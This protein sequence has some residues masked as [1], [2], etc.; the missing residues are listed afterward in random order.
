MR[1]FALLTITLA[2]MTGL[3]ALG[4][5]GGGGGSE[6]VTYEGSTMPSVIDTT[7]AVD[8][9]KSA[10]L[11]G[12]DAQGVLPMSV[13]TTRVPSDP[14]KMV[15]YA[16]GV[17]A[18]AGVSGGVE[19]LSAVEP[20]AYACSVDE[21][22]D[23]SGGTITEEFCIDPVREKIRMTLSADGYDDGVEAI[24]GVIIIEGGDSDVTVIFRDYFY[25]DLFAGDEDFYADGIVT[26]RES[27]STITIT[28]NLSMYD[29]LT[30]EGFWLNNYRL[31]VVED[32][33][34]EEDTVTI[35]GRFYDYHGGYV[36]IST[37]TPLVVPWNEDYPVIGELQMTG[38]NGYWIKI[39]FDQDISD[40][41]WFQ[42]D[43]NVDE[44]PEYDWQSAWEYWEPLV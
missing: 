13:G 27:G 42:V 22:D 14:A 2:L 26:M 44:D 15:A 4:C 35:T 1:K 30:D 6:E 24:D 18:G 40:I 11:A 3:M 34:N 20:L 28:Y 23:G 8:L 9:A 39:R 16:R 43:V 37:V 10:S 17:V 21:Y 33:F 41:P 7:G 25:A 19:L 31:V 29:Y 32:T 12:Q 38:A 36:D 5:G